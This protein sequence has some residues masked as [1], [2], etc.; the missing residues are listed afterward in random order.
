VHGVLLRRSGDAPMI[1]RIDEGHLGLTPPQV[2][3]PP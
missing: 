1:C 2:A 3:L